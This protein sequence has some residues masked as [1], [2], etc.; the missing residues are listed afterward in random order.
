[1]VIMKRIKA[2]VVG[3]GIY[4]SHHINAYLNN[5]KTELVGVCDL[6]PKKLDMVKKEYSINTYTDLEEMIKKEKPDIISIA[7]PD[8]YHF[9]PAKTAIEN[10]IDVLVEKPLATSRKECEEL[11]KLA[12]AHNVKVGVDFHKRWD[13][14]SINLKLELEKEDTGKIVRGYVSMDDI[15]DVP[16]N[17]LPW[18]RNSSPAY[19]LGVHCYDLIRY[20]IEDE[21]TEVYAVGSKGVLSGMG[22]DTYDNVQAIL[23]FSK[24][25]TWTVENSWILPDKFPKS[26]DGRM[27]IVT[28]KKYLRSDSQNRGVEFFSDTKTQT[29]NSYFITYRNNKAFGFGID[30]INDFT[31]SIISGEKFMANA[32]DGLE[33]TKIADAV[34]ESIITGKP[35]KLER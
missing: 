7:T 28:E 9:G 11:I 23:K 2:A 30:P 26:N 19:F 21:V 24:G 5:D 1:M 13:P 14:A 31:D 34:H 25:S 29:P 15:I 33:A 16:V 10:N 8:P 12:E 27:C 4:G 20:L 3:A 17:W 22:I 32:V 6:D 18:S 35:V